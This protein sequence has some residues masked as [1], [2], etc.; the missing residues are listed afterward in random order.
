MHTRMGPWALYV[1][2]VLHW[3]TREPQLSQPTPNLPLSSPYMCWVE[4]QLQEYSG[5]H[6]LSHMAK[7]LGR[8]GWIKDL[9]WAADHGQSRQD[10]IYS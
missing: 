3:S 5:P 2:C 1:Y 6:E 9:D 8:Y 4:C 7:G 10:V